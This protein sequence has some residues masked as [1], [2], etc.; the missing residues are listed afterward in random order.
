MRLFQCELSRAHR[1]SIQFPY[2]GLDLST[3]VKMVEIYLV[4]E[5]LEEIK[6]S[7]LNT[8]EID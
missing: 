2:F 8:E 6:Q 7:I 4:T 5:S 3:F 1:K